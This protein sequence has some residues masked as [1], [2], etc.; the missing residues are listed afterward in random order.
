MEKNTTTSLGAL[1]LGVALGA[2]GSSVLASKG[3]LVVA[4]DVKDVQLTNEALNAASVFLDTFWTGDKN[5]V[6]AFNC[7]KYSSGWACSAHGEKT[8]PPNTASSDKP[9]LVKSVK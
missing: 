2:G 7:E 3:D 4:H 9:L 8:V 5:T 1:M 6:V